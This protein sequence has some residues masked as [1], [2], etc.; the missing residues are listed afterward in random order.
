MGMPRVSRKNDDGAVVKTA[1]GF[2][3]P[4]DVRA[5]SG[6][7]CSMSEA[8]TWAFSYLRVDVDPK[9]APSLVAWRLLEEGRKDPDAIV[10]MF[11]EVAKKQA[12]SEDGDDGQNR[13]EWDGK[14]QW[15]VLKNL[16]EAM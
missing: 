8:V 14:R 3:H 16:T 7:K 9:D 13:A 6:R 5:L 2:V 15:D 12:Q 10:G 1:Q 11:M 4:K